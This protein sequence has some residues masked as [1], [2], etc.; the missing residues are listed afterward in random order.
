MSPETG[1]YTVGKSFSVTVALNTEGKSVNAADGRLTFNPRELQVVQISRSSSIFNL[2]TEEPSFSNAAGTISFGGGSPSGY[3][4]GSGS[5]LSITFRALGAGTPKVTFQSGSVLAAD[6]LGTNILTAMNGASFT[7]AAEA[8]SPAPEYIPPANT[9]QAPKVVSNTH[10]DQEKWF[11]EKNAELSWD[12]PGG[13]TAVRTL[14]D[15]N[16]GTVPTVVYEGGISSKSLSD[17]PEGTSYFHV[18]FKNADGWGRI[19]HYKLNIDTESPKDF[20]VNEATDSEGRKKLEFK[21]TDVSPVRFYKIQ[22]DGGDPIEYTD[23]KEEKS[24]VLPPLTPG[25]HTISVEAFDSAGNTAIASISL[26]IEAFEKPLFTEFPSRVN[27]GVVPAFKGTTKP[28]AT[29]FIEARNVN[30]GSDLLPTANGSSDPYTV[31]ADDN[32]NFIFIPDKP[33]ERGV[34]TLSATAQDNLGRMSE[35]SDELRF[36]VDEPGYIVL[37]NRLVSFLSML[38]PLVALV[39]LLT[40]GTWYLW[41][42]LSRWKRKVKKETYEAEEVLKRE[43]QVLITNMHKNVDALREA[44]KGKFTKQEAELIEQLE[45]DVRHALSKVGKEIEDIEETVT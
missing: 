25:Y 13:V 14:L 34:Y 12:V 9:P 41:Y 26:T 45:V 30:T 17:L 16:P 3:K 6:G 27:T 37:G 1:V 38:I 28:N 23:G 32:G 11:K 33:F 21:L 18:Q 31:L 39:L 8:D 4:G 24:Y 19:T 7:I 2:W 35:K 5:I 40:F 36:V 44:K 10:P 15:T 20:S 42:S 22:I 29:V 43:F